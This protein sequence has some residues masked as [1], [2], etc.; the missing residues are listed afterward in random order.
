MN[1]SSSRVLEPSDRISEVLFGLIMVLTFTGSL[2]VAE[3]GREDIRT[4]LVGALGCNLAWGIIDAVFY[5][6]GSLAEK[7]RDLAIFRAVRTV[8][9][10][11][12]AQRLI[13]EALPSVIASVVR[14]PEFD[15]MHQRLQ[16]LPEPPGPARL[17]GT[18]WRGAGGV[19]LLVFLSTLPVAVPFMIM[20]DATAAMRASNAVAVAMLFVAGAA[21]GRVV[22]RSPWVLGAIMV[23]LGGVLVALT[24]ALGG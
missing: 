19:F 18:D 15:A 1:A 24:I 23:A 4:M 3:A 2:S 22:G 17:D 20:Q 5:L 6:M 11:R 7:G 10:P 21:Y 9:D 8:A 13:A 16:L 14:P 12:E